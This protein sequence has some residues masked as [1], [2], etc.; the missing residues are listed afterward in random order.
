[1]K[2]FPIICL[3]LHL[4]LAQAQ[5]DTLPGGL[6]LI[7]DT[8]PAA[9]QLLLDEESNILLLDPAQSRLYKY[10]AATGYDSLIRIGGKGYRSD[11]FLHPAKM[12]LRNRQHLFILDDVQRRIV[13]LNPN[14]RV[15]DA[16]DFA[17]LAEPGRPWA[18]VEE[19]Y[20]LSFDVAPGGECFVL[21]SF[22]NQIIKIGL[23][24][25][26]LTRFGGVDYGA[27]SLYHPTDI[28][29]DAQNL[30][31][32]SD[33]VDQQ[34]S[35]YDQY[36]AFRYHL[37]PALPFRWRHLRLSGDQLLLFDARHLYIEHLPS[38]R[39]ETFVLPP[40]L[41][42]RDITGRREGLYLLG[43]KTVHLYRF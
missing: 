43:E 4:G 20:P 34:V 18:T 6:E 13:V 9:I 5:T 42:L 2:L 10:F 30:V 7:G 15:G 25:E 35:V 12:V 17:T 23:R 38:R 32:V 28:A 33:T 29:I 41:L 31:Y 16:I 3:L 1:M 21:N 24:G 11:A 26:L 36:G 8:F 40:G 14:F 19:I 27:G 22:D 37:A 39:G